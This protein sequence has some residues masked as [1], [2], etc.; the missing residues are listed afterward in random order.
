MRS[1][2]KKYSTS[3]KKHLDVER[4]TY[5]RVF[6]PPESSSAAVVELSTTGEAGR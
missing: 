4:D 3:Y 2:A 1:V 5:F 6:R